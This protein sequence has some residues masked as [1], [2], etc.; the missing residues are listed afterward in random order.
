MLRDNLYRKM[1]LLD[2]NIGI[3]AYSLHQAALNLR[4]RIVS[5]VQD[6][7]FRVS[8]F[9]MQV[10]LALLIAVEVNSPLCQLPDLFRSH[11]YYLF[12]GL[13]VTDIV[14]GN[15]GVCYMLV[16]GVKFQICH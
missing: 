4:T 10:K 9:T 6:A 16:K 7:E 2:I 3:A 1:V 14:T 5:M 15:N 8:A 13:A 12:Y 11:A